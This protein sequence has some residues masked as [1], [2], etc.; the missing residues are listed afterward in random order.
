METN[1]TRMC[2]TVVGLPE[3]KV[4]GVEHDD[5]GEPLRVHVETIAEF[6]G[7][8]G[9]GTRA[10]GKGPSAGRAGGSAGVRSPGGAGVAQAS[11]VMPG[12]GL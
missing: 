4:L 2:A 9:C 1:A 3:I 10:Q 11:M 5:P 7:C 8:G 6:E 12:R